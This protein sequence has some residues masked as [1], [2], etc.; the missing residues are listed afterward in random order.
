M[1]SFRRIPI[2]AALVAL[3]GFATRSVDAEIRVSPAAI[4]LDSPESSQQLL[5]TLRHKDGRTRDVSRKVEFAF[6]NVEVAEVTQRGLVR[7]IRDGQ[8]E[9][10]VRVRWHN[11]NGA[12]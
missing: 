8:T 2:I 9:L 5:V 11:E 12:D 10:M 3:V 4:V 6:K 7:P 1:T